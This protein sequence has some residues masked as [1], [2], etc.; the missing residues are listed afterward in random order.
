M[1]NPGL[2]LIAAQE[3]SY[4]DEL[5]KLIDF[6]NK[7]LKDKNLVFGLSMK[8]DDKMTVSIYRA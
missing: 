4:N 6:L 8:G 7:A 5:Y 3:V 2:E 1:G